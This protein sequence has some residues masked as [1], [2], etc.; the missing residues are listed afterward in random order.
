MNDPSSKYCLMVVK[1]L[2]ENVV[3]FSNNCV[4]LT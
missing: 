2:C 3:T 4:T 1:P